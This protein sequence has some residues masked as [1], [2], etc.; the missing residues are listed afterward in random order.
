M[1]EF[2]QERRV[3]IKDLSGYMGFVVG[4][5]GSAPFAWQYLSGY[6]EA[7][8]PSTGLLYFVVIILAAGALVGT[9]GLL[10][11]ASAG[12][13]WEQVHR[14]R[15]PPSRD[16]TP[17][18]TLAARAVAPAGTATLAA[19]STAPEVQALAGARPRSLVGGASGIRYDDQG[20][21]VAPFLALAQRV[22]PNDYDPI[23]AS[24][25][26]KRTLNVG[27]WDGDRLIGAVRVLTDGYFFATIPEILVDPEY[28]GHGVGRELM[29]RALALAPRGALFFGARPQSV[30]FFERLGCERGPEGFIMRRPGSPTS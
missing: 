5:L 21:A 11:G 18:P 27:A 4:F 28:Q 6:F 23:R 9:G 26:L 12:F 30:G 20:F 3:A 19:P 1:S 17:V 16:D 15:R 22:W 24:A 14:W 2:Y 10:L 25:A 8:D 29:Q 13:V 7:N